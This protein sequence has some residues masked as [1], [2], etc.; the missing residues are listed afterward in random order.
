MD[1]ID[2]FGDDAVGSQ[3]AELMRFAVTSLAAD[4]VLKICRWWN[5]KIIIEYIQVLS[6]SCFHVLFN[7]Q[8]ADLSSLYLNSRKYR[9]AL[10]FLVT[11]Y[12]SRDARARSVLS[13]GRFSEVLAILTENGDLSVNDTD[14]SG[15]SA[16]H[17]A[18]KYTGNVDVIK[19][20]GQKLQKL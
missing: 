6:T 9:T 16:L 1:E 3:D 17:L 2:S 13:L 8:T 15:D 4:D 10:H 20:C 14:V 18:C 19:V 12:C 5:W 7:R 11:S